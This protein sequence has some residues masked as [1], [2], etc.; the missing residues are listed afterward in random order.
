VNSVKFMYY[1]LQR[2]MRFYLH[3]EINILLIIIKRH[4]KHNGEKFI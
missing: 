2:V 4:I 1:A 3:E